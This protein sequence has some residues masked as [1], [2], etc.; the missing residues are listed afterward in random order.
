MFLYP[1]KQTKL[2]G[3]SYNVQKVVFHTG[4]NFSIGILR[5]KIPT[6]PYICLTLDTY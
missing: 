3:Y 6:A 5:Q 2:I 4:L 1:Y